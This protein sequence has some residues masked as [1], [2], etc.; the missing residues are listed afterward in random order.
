QWY[1]PQRLV[2][3]GADLITT[4]SETSAKD[5]KNT[6][7]TKLTPTVVYNAPQQFKTT[8][9][10][11]SKE[12]QNIVYMGSFMLYKNVETLIKGMEW[13]PGR[14]LHLLSRITVARRQELQALVPEGANVI[15]HNGVTDN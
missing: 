5:I 6:N 10:L 2:L 12:V 4:V 15:F 11:A 8:P 7:M 9:I 14:T 3:K 1:W 13:L